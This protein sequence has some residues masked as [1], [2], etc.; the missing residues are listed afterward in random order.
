LA[1]KRN[2][3]NERYVRNDGI[4]GLYKR[5]KIFYRLKGGKWES[6]GTTVRRE[7][8]KLKRQLDERDI[9]LKFLQKNGLGELE[10]SLRRVEEKVDAISTAPA[11]K[12]LARVPQINEADIATM[13]VV[14]VF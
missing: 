9:A 12:V 7:A 14:W 11:Q 8:I 3:A 10:A 6:L 4:R 1:G 2:V 5:G 13:R